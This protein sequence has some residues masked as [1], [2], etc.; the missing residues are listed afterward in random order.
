MLSPDLPSCVFCGI[1]VYAYT[2]ITVDKNITKKRGKLWEAG[3]T[4]N[5]QKPHWQPTIVSSSTGSNA[6]AQRHSC[7][8]TTNAHENKSLKWFKKKGKLC[9]IRN[10]FSFKSYVFKVWASTCHSISPQQECPVCYLNGVHTWPWWIF[11]TWVYV[12]SILLQAKQ[13]PKLC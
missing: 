13:T 7:R 1:K 4:F 2:H 11:R 5:C 9:R 3:K 10:A 12:L 6:L 8:Q